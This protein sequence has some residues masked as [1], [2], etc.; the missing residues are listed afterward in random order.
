VRNGARIT[1]DAPLDELLALVNP[2]VAEMGRI[3]V[4]GAAPAET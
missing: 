3:S 4:A 2:L 1:P